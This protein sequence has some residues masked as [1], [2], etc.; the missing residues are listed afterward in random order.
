[1]K[2]L[3]KFDTVA[4]LN[5]AIANSTIG[6]IGLAY[7]NGTPVMKNKEGG[8]PVPSISVLECTYMVL[9]D[10]VDEPLPIFADDLEFIGEPMPFTAMEI[11]GV[12]YDN[13]GYSDY[14][15]TF[16]TMGIHNVNFILANSTTLGNNIFS[17]CDGLDSVII[18]NTVTSIG[19]GT[20]AA[21]HMSSVTIPSSVT[22]IGEGAFYKVPHIYYN[23]TA[24]GAPWGALAIN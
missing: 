14:Y 19:E 10:M 12:T 9:E 13:I 7:N 15:F 17:A 23:G 6:M 8:S 21:T 5:A 20:F 22:S 1:M 18:P 4:D 3:R 24:T 11:D 2:H 16:N